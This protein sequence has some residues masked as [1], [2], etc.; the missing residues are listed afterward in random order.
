[1][2]GDPVN[3]TV[4]LEMAA[5]GLPVFPAKVTFNEEKQLWE[6]KPHIQNWQQEATTDEKTL[7][8]WWSEWPEA[9]AG[10]E[11]GRANLIMLDLDRHGGPGRRCRHLRGSRSPAAR[12]PG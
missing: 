12:S 5:A 2:H 6:K 7:R 10:I 1:M 8:Y 11:L 3:L 4:A 9:V